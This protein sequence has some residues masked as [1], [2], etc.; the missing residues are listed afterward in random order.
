[1]TEREQHFEP[2]IPAQEQLNPIEVPAKK[3]EKEQQW[4]EFEEKFKK[5]TD[6]LG[7]EI[8]PGIFDAVVALNALGI[9][10]RQSCEGHVD[11]GRIAPWVDVQTA[12]EPK[13]FVNEDAVYQ[14]IAAKHNIPVEEAQRAAT[15]LGEI[16]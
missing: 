6:G 12:G 1:M 4:Q 2:D 7:Y 14:E 9:N 8:E 15:E 5:E 13:R 3:S 11:R 10:T 16:A